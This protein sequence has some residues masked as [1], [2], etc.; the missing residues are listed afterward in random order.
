VDERVAVVIPA[1]NEENLIGKTLAALFAQYTR[2]SKVVVVNDGSTDRTTEVASA[3]GAE[4][5]AMKDRGYSA[6]GSPVFA[7]VVN[8]GLDRLKESGYAE[9]DDYIMILGADHIL[10]PNYVTC[11]LDMMAIEKEIVVCSGQISGEES[12]IPRGSGRIVS[13]DFWN[14]IGLRYPENYGFETY[15]LIKAQQ[16]GYKVKVMDELM[17]TTQ[18]KTRRSYKSDVY[19]SYGKSLKALGYNRLYSAARIGRISLHSPRGAF[20]MLKGY[21]NKDIETYEPELRSYLRSAQYE[22]IKRYVTK[23]VRALSEAT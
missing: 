12:V 23:P 1:R 8:C 14:K 4:V 21:I 16:L 13:A 2:P 11:V 22:R 15:L 20:N 9:N 10:P 19:I 6:Q 18:R 7:R 3:A 17:T 5:I